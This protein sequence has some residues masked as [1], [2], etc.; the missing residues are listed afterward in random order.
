M[1]SL[2]CRYIWSWTSYK[3]PFQSFLIHLILFIQLKQLSIKKRKVFMLFIRYAFLFQYFICYRDIFLLQF[4][5]KCY[6][7]LSL[8]IPNKFSHKDHYDQKTGVPRNIWLFGVCFAKPPPETLHCDS[9]WVN[10]MIQA[11]IYLH[12]FFTYMLDIINH[13]T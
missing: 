5:L 4:S 9:Q 11:K 6:L 3:L 8:E 10:H 13:S 2:C 12:Y 7:L 1:T